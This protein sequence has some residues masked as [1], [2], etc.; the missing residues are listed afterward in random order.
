MTQPTIVFL[1]AIIALVLSVVAAT[2]R[3]P[4]SIPVILI[5]IIVVVQVAPAGWPKW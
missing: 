3:C 1:L 4:L 2:G 5:S